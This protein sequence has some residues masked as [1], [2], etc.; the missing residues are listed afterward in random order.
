AGILGIIKSGAAY[1][2]VDPGY[3]KDRIRYMISDSS[4]KAILVYNTNIETEL[5]VIDLKDKTIWEG[6]GQNP[7]ILSRPEDVAYVIYTS[8]TTGRPKGVMVENHG[9]ANLKS[10]FEASFKITPKDNILQFA[11]ISFDAS[12]WEM[13]MGLLTGAT[14]VVVPSE[15]IMDTVLFEKYCKDN[16]VTVA[17]LPPQYYLTL[18]NFAPR[19]LITAGSESSKKIIE[20]AGTDIRYIN[21]YGPTETTVCATHWEY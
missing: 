17:T 16:N 11:N 10:Y 20:K 18:N 19:L 15:C 3:P 12:V 6:D 2:P 4:P 1:V 8:G 21:A 14:L 5:P 9:I 7:E 13:S